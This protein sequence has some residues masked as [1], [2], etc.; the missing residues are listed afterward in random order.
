MPP[1]LCFRNAPKADAN[2]GRVWHVSLDELTVLG[3]ILSAPGEVLPWP[4]DRE[5]PAGG[6]PQRATNGLGRVIWPGPTSYGLLEN[7][8]PRRPVRIPNMQYSLSYDQVL[9]SS[10]LQQ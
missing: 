3:I 9:L 7:W 8:R 6:P 2:S 4:R 10:L 1:P 5:I